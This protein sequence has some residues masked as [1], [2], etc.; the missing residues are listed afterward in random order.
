M[1][2]RLDLKLWLYASVATFVLLSLASYVGR[3]I[4]PA[5]PSSATEMSAGATAMMSRILI[6]MGRLVFSLMFTYIYFKGHEG[7]PWLGEGF[8]YGLCI[9][10]LVAVPNL[11]YTLTAPAPQA[12]ESIGP[13]VKNVV[14]L[15]LAGPLV[16]LIYRPKSARAAA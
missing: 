13:L 8:R 1:R 9:A 12:A 4:I 16:A 11:V 14:Q 3:M 10:L 2:P 7:K 6:Y 15:L 5:P